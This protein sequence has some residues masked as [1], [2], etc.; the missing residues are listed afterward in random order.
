[1]PVRVGVNFKNSAR[2]QWIGSH[3][4]S[5]RP[6]DLYIGNFQCYFRYIR[7]KNGLKGWEAGTV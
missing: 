5:Y 7:P 6:V 3:N 1:M 2:L 4:G